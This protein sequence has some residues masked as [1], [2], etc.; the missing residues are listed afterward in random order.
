MTVPRGIGVGAVAEITYPL[1]CNHTN[2]T[3]MCHVDRIF[4]VHATLSTQ[5]VKPNPYY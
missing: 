3:E 5:R 2:K 1:L 4:P